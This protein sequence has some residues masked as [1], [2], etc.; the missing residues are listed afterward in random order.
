MIVVSNVGEE[1]AKT[2]MPDLQ[3]FLCLYISYSYELNHLAE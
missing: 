1:P 2:V 3:A